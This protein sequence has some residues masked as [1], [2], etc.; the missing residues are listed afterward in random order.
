MKLITRFK[1]AAVIPGLIAVNHHAAIRPAQ[2]QI[3]PKRKNDGFARDVGF[4]ARPLST[5]RQ[6]EVE[7]ASKDDRVSLPHQIT[8]HGVNHFC[9]QQEGNRIG[10]VES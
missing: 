1:F 8:G 2:E 7:S 3:G 9:F 5:S 4:N 6:T 10:P